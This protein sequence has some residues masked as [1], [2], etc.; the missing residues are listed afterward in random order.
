MK[1]YKNIERIKEAELLFDE[2]SSALEGYE[3]ALER[4]LEAQKLFRRLEA[5]YGSGEWME[6]F[7]ADEKGKLPTDMKRGV[8]SE[9]GL[10][11][12]LEDNGHYLEMLGINEE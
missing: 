11:D 10:Y 4:F 12:L 9:D 3:N 5:Y 8:L 7:E 2:A 1:E 6:D